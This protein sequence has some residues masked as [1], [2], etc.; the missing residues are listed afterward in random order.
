MKQRAGMLLG[1]AALSLGA[2]PATVPAAQASAAPGERSLAK[3]LTSDGNR[4]DRNPRDFDIV[5]EAALAVVA[6]KPGS[7]VA[8]LADGSQ[9]LTA[10]VPTDRAFRLLVKDLTGRWIASERKLFNKLVKIAGVDT[11]EAVLRYHVVPGRT[12]TSK[13]VLRADGA[14][15]TTAARSTV[16]VDVRHKPRLR[17]VLIDKDR[18]VRNPRVLLR[19][20]DINRGNLQVAHGIN[21]VLRPVDL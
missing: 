13:K 12:L 5:T 21:R 4:F 2:L 14:K 7:P 20:V 3:V 8:L 19:A 11:I 15:L 6:T 16:K 18:D 9:R 1:V 17:I 10:F